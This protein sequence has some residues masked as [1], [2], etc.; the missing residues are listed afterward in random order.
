MSMAT[1]TDRARDKDPGFL[2][3]AAAGGHDRIGRHRERELVDDDEA[4]R[5]AGHVD[6][7]PEAHRR[8]QHGVT[9]GAKAADQHQLGRVA[10][11]QRRAR[12]AAA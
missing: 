6:A 7:L 1:A 10:L 9:V 2:D 12:H 4:E 3:R 5:V 11:H 8:D